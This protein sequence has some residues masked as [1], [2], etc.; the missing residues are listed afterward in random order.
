MSLQ[1]PTAKMSKSDPNP[2]SRI[3]LT[4]TPE[5][6]TAKING[7]K[8]DSQAGELTYDPVGRPG[9]SNL[10]DILA[11]LHPDGGGRT[12]EDWAAELRTEPLRRVKLRVAEAVALALDG[13]RHRYTR[14]MERDEG[15]YL[16]HVAEYGA[17]KA[18]ARAAETMEIVHSAVGL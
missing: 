3:L 9:V 8:T 12:A 1:T 15:M 4:D 10:L 13:V 5:E 6:I 2:R 16:R 14:I 17:Q 18:R 11:A 7:A